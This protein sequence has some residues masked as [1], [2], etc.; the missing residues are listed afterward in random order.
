MES[1]KKL[2]FELVEIATVFNLKQ[3]R[4]C[5]HLNEWLKAH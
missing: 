4:N 2:P 1:V 5:E 3:N